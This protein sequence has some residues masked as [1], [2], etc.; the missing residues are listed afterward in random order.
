MAQ[1]NNKRS[2][3]SI[4]KKLAG[5]NVLICLLVLGIVGI[6]L[7]SFLDVRQGI[8][9]LIDQEVAQMLKNAKIERDLSTVFADTSLLVATF[10]DV[11]SVLETE[12]DRLS[13]ILQDTLAQ[14]EADNTRL[15]APVRE[16]EQAFK[17]LLE[18]CAAIQEHQQ[19]IETDAAQFEQLL[20]ELD[21]LVAERMLE[22]SALELS[23]LE[24]LGAVMPGYH[25]TLLNVA[26]QLNAMIQAHL[27]IQEVEQEYAQQIS[28]LLDELAA[29]LLVINSTGQAFQP[30]GAQLTALTQQYQ[31]HIANLAAELKIFQE[32]LRMLRTAE[33]RVKQALA[34]MDEALAGA[35]EA[36][37]QRAD[38]RIRAALIL[39]LSLSAVM[40]VALVGVSVYGVRM[41]QP[42]RT[43][44]ATAER[45][46][47]GDL[48]ET[49]K[50]SRSHDEIGQLLTA[51]KRMFE[52]FQRVVSQVKTSSDNVADGSQAMS[53]SSAEMSEGATSQ[54][55]A[56]E[57]A[58]SSMEQMAAN[59]RQNA[60]NALQT[61]KIAIQAANDARESGAAVAE[62]VNAMREIV[63]KIAI[64]DD[65]T[66]QTRL[67][68]L[69]ATIE[70]ARAQEHG[71][72]F[73]VVAAEVRN[74][75]E[76]SQAASTEITEL[77]G[78]SMS[79]AEQA[80]AM[81]TRLVPDIQKT[82]EL[83][84][85]I[86]AAS[87]EQTSGTD[88]INRAIQQL[89]TVTQQ[90]SAT[91]EEL[92]ATA[93]ELASQ[94]EMLQQTIAF[95]N[96]G[97]A[98][99]S[100]RKPASQAPQAVSE[101]APARPPRSA[102]QS[103]GAIRVIY[104]QPEVVKAVADQRQGV[105]FVTWQTLRRDEIVKACCQAQLEEVRNGRRVIVV[106]SSAARGGASQAVQTWFAEELFP[107]LNEA[108]LQAIITVAPQNAA[109]RLSAKQWTRTGA[110]FGFDMYETDSLDAAKTLARTILHQP[111]FDAFDEEFERY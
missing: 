63:Q 50:E 25:E 10:T 92:S 108:G 4:V 94:A 23:A 61:E 71:K 106:D 95:F 69:N 47:N 57:E 81:L 21:A 45:L 100:R 26:I 42:L 46:A 13:G 6:T 48:T 73:A 36:L 60:D 37:Q 109:V 49:I 41:V 76:R 3:I 8:A 28:Q 56:A 101:A 30:L 32:Q 83:V 33:T 99:E 110:P 34:N 15:S 72:G 90:N 22:G 96:V 5:M 2:G 102:G 20:A 54:A 53:A 39:I 58:S 93:E 59:I 79:V 85:E 55:A 16:F 97:Q 38:G 111:D 107:A 105:I 43:L 66:R 40:I 68:S 87:K 31:Q 86:S 17:T 64:I 75:A 70:A 12:G 82:S 89:D 1:Q 77:A 14:I 103:S 74:L 18:H 7:F 44:V 27:G 11:Q 80:G 52:T 65:I 67:L 51:M 104:E 19:R 78:T 98:A 62:A 35:S 24:N 84:Q 9:T 88:Q 29:D 91:S